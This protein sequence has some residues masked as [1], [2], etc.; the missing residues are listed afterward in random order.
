MK[1]KM[2]LKFKNK[3]SLSRNAFMVMVIQ[4]LYLV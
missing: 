4:I 1:N 3:I 2:S